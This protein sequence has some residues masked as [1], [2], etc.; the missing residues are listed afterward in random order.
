MLAPLERPFLP[1]A[2]S[3]IRAAHRIVLACHVNPDG[4][5]LGSLLGLTFALEVLGKEVVPLSAD[6]VPPLLEF[7]PGAGRVQTATDRR[8][9]DLSIVVDSGD[10]SR[11]GMSRD[12]VLSSPHVLDID[13]HVTAGAFGDLRLLDSDA[14]ATAEILYDLIV[15]LGVPVTTDIA[16]CLLCGLLTDTGSFRFMN[17]TPRTMALAGE[18]IARGASPNTIA[19]AVFENKPWAAQKL[20][21]R[22]LDSLQRSVD[23]RVVWAHIRQSDFVELGGTDADTEGV[24]SAIRAVRG[25]EVAA[26]LREM[27]SGR[28]RVSLRAREPVDV[29][30]VAA[31][32]GGGGHRLAAGCTLEG[33]LEQAETLLVAEL[34]NALGPAI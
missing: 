11:V 14:A 26:L 6:G 3:A 13:H 9:F 10:L 20:M 1:E 24:V 18:L 16:Q 5:A 30:T 2:A 25:A 12:T 15:F 22:A 28:L 8:D 32:F 34:Q 21:G 17:V 4:D 27:P 31:R 33:P 7:L 19:E 23:G 29:A